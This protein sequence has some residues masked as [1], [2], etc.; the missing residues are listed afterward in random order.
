MTTTIDEPLVVFPTGAGGPVIATFT[1]P[2][3]LTWSTLDTILTYPTTYVEYLGFDGAS[4]TT[5]GCAAGV[6]PTA[7]PLP[8][9]VVAASLVYPSNDTTAGLPPGLVGYLDSLPGFTAQLGEP[10]NSCA[11]SIPAPPPSSTASTSQPSSTVVNVP[12]S[13]TTTGQATSIIASTSPTIISATSSPSSSAVTSA[14]S[15]TPSSGS[16]SP[17][18]TSVST[19]KQSDTTTTLSPSTTVTSTSYSTETST[20][21]SSITLASTAPIFSFIVPPPVTTTTVTSTMA[22][23]ANTAPQTFALSTAH[24]FSTVT[25]NPVISKGG[26]VTTLSTTLSAPPTALPISVPSSVSIELGGFFSY[27]NSL[28]A[29]TTPRATGSTTVKITTM[30][31]SAVPHISSIGSS[32]VLEGPLTGTLSGTPYRVINATSATYAL[33]NGT[34]TTNVIPYTGRAA[35]GVR[36]VEAGLLQCLIELALLAVLL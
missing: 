31:T 34:S 13:T 24:V 21:T 35:P 19:V 7:I 20:L 12:S 3:Q 1:D 26:S 28:T 25:I 17:V 33:L 30:T 16:A 11:T 2:S 4:A 29:S 32:S 6:T 27:V 5:S 14:T 15:T 10:V 8:S 9:N 18:S 23:S 22:S 36:P